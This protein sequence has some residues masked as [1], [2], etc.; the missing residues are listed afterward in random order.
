MLLRFL[1]GVDDGRGRGGGGSRAVL[2]HQG[3]GI[4]LTHDH[5]ADDYQ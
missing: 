3:R 4:R 1:S 5:K 2:C